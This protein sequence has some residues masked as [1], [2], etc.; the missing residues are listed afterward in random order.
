MSGKKL[1]VAAL[2]G[3]GG[4]GQFAVRTAVD[5][6]F[7]DEVII[8][9]RDGERAGSFS[10]KCG[11]KT[12][13]VQL[14][15][16]DASALAELFERVDVVLNT[17]GPFYRFGLPVLKA[18]IAAGR[19][20]LDICDDWEP[21]LDMLELHGEAQ[22]EG[23]TAV[24]GL[25]A[26]PGLTN[27]LAAKAASELD[28]VETIVTGWSASGGAPEE[29]LPGQGGSFG[30]AIEH[31][32]LQI[33]G[34]IRLL[35]DGA[36]T[37]VKPLEEVMLDY[38]GI[39]SAPVYTLG[40]PEPITFH[41]RWPGLKHSCNAMIVSPRMLKDLR[42]LATAIDSGLLSL[43]DG[44]AMVLSDMASASTKPKSSKPSG[45][46]LPPLF[47]W[48]RGVQ[49]GREKTVGATITAGISGGMG[50]V[51]GVPMA[52]GLSLFAGKEAPP[53]GVYAP[54]EI[55]DPDSYFNELAPFCSPARQG[56]R[57][58]VAVSSSP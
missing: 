13:A 50:G 37:D 53:V 55:F 20:Y 39:G 18:S 43:E 47:A 41:R 32:L 3:C 33:S 30:A 19:H 9:D 16:E 27:L 21:T 4:M 36:L 45:P 49:G 34:T 52:A 6:D 38:P 22:K 46:R 14:D 25:G 58:L 48:A 5:F 7:V 51:T 23:M 31:W 17:V 40:H 10:E 24:I 12:S 42:E 11:T 29:S 28:E 1:R 56:V 8:A 44:A 15:I 57:D 2:G 26:S 35:K 54:E